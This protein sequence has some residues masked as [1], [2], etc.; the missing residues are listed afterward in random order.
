M[1]DLSTTT[2]RMIAAPAQKV[3]EAWLNADTLTKFMLPRAD[4]PEPACTTDPIEGGRFDILMMV[5]ENEIPHAGTYKEIS[6]YSRLVFTWESP[7]S[8]DDSTVTVDF[9]EVEGGTN[10][11]LT[12]VK[13]PSEE[14][15]DNHNQGWSHILKMLD[16]FAA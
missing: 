13:F 14:S 15:R 10:V 16:E 2:S 4:M 3:F 5:G 11:T 6:R 7:F 8:V 9:D 1:T 12:H